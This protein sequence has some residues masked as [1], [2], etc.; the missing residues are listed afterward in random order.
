MEQINAVLSGIV[1]PVI[2]LTAGIIFGFRLR[3]FFIL[4]PVKFLK[5]LC[6]ASEGGGISPLR[7]LTLSLAGT[8]GVGNMAGV[9]TAITAGGAG[10]V[11]WMLVSAI[12]GM[13]VK[14][15]EVAL[16]VLHRRK[17]A[18][19]YF[20]G[21]MYYIKDIFSGFFPRAASVFGGI[22]AVLCVFNTLMTGNI[23]QVK[24][25][26]EVF[27][28]FPP[29]ILGGVLA[30]AAFAVACGKASRV[31][32]VTLYLIPFLSAGYIVISLA[33]IFGNAERLPEIFSEIISS[34]FSLR[35]VAGGV[36]G[37]AMARA[38]RFGVTRGIFSNEAGLGSSPSAHSSANTKSAHHQGCF[39]IFEVFA[40]TVVLCTMTA[41][42]ILLADCGGENGGI[43][44]TLA[45]YT[46]LAGKIPGYFIGIS[47]ILFAF[48]TIICSMQ[49]GKVALGYLFR[50]NGAIYVYFFLSA[51]ATVTGSVI[52][53]EFMWQAADM[54]VSLMT[55]LNVLC[56]FF[57]FPQVRNAKNLQFA[58][59]LY[60]KA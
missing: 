32:A 2:L 60:K 6:E 40:D 57:A 58:A 1:M 18:D 13:S 34:A 49:Y 46:A 21:A 41:L 50:G 28:S 26:A 59:D 9:A 29:I 52:N 20:G 15:T 37:Y 42:V 31:S 56:L 43:P 25:A 4:H 45:S 5:T 38:I 44:L 24:A 35:S 16:G 10:S 27:P 51:A 30:A 23:V 8:L 36:G 14:Y 33:I 53:G 47:V 19:G 12:I 22:F 11:F 54:S 3:F 48:A 17:N 55:A 39:G 7:A